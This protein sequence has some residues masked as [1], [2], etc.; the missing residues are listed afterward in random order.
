M[1]KVYRVN[2]FADDAILSSLSAIKQAQSR[3][4]LLTGTGSSPTILASQIEVCD[5]LLAE[6]SG[7]R[8]ILA[9]ISN[10]RRGQFQDLG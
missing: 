7:I 10:R 9:G 2:E 6:I 1:N 3:R 4:H 5:L 8:N